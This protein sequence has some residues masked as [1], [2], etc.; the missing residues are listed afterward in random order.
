M[1]MAMVANHMNQRP[2]YDN[3]GNPIYIPV[4]V[5]W[6][7][8]VNEEGWSVHMLAFLNAITDD[9]RWVSMHGMVVFGVRH[10]RPFFL[11]GPSVRRVKSDSPGEDID[12]EEE[13]DEVETNYPRGEIPF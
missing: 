1:K 6:Y 10:G 9:W 13:V 4:F 11:F 2:M 7:R 3:D 12:D 5:W 8:H